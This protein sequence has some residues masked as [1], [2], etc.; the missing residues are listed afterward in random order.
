[1]LGR[2]EYKYQLPAHFPFLVDDDTQTVI[3]PVLLYLI[4]R[5]IKQGKYKSGNTLKAV[6]HDLADWWRFLAT[7]ER[8]W[9]DIDTDFI[10]EYR[11]QRLNTISYQ[12][13]ENL[14]PNTIRRR[15]GA[16]FTFYEWAHFRG[17]FDTKKLDKRET[18][19]I[20]KSIDFDP[21]AHTKLS[22]NKRDVS[23]LLPEDDSNQTIKVHVF[24]R[25]DLPLLLSELGPLPSERNQL[26]NHPARDRLASELA[27]Q[28]GLRVDEVAQL[29]IYQILDLTVPLDAELHETVTMEVTKTKGLKA[30]KVFL[31]V[32]LVHELRLYIDTERTEALKAGQKHGLKGKVKRPNS[33]FVNGVDARQHA[34]KAI[35]ADTF[36]RQFRSAVLRAGLIKHVEKTDP[37]TGERYITQDARYTFHDCRHSYAIYT[38]VAFREAGHPAP[39]LEVSQR[40]G[41]ASLKTTL[42]IYLKHLDENRMTINAS[43]FAA[44]RGE[45]SGN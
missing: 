35:H 19:R 36:D 16:V 32:Y 40:L 18:R 1:M 43:V 22:I 33:V 26:N 29:T 23:L 30:R 45:W 25:S 31:P 38:Y 11:E 14:K 27:L 21:L 42:D 15:M 24:K 8:N 39:W 41:H 10:I 2:P 28:T 44:I 34:G 9:N 5:F 37:H 7:T 13:H 17:L 4:D 12:T 6:A 3:E 20:S